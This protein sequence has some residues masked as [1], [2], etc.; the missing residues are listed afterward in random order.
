MQKYL[1]FVIVAAIILVAWIVLP[2]V[3]KHYQKEVV[4]FKKPYCPEVHVKVNDRYLL[5]PKV[6]GGPALSYQRQMLAWPYPC[7]N[8][9]PLEVDLFQFS[10]TEKLGYEASKDGKPLGGTFLAMQLSGGYALGVEK[11]DGYEVLEAKLADAGMSIQDL[12][13][14]SGYYVWQPTWH[15]HYYISA[16]K[17]LTTPRGNPLVFYCSPY[18]AKANNPLHCEFGIIWKESMGIGLKQIDVSYIP[19]DQWKELYERFISYVE[20]IDITETHLE[21][22]N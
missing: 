15:Q 18:A 22:K 9:N 12:P 11:R 10:A 16:G 17:N 7:P 20:T 14:Q 19:P 6:V 8:S 3:K 1:P 4:Q 21:R 2:I 13:V 5:L